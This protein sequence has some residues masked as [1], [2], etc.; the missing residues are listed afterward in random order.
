MENRLLNSKH[1]EDKLN[2][3]EHEKI[4]ADRKVQELE[5]SLERAKRL[6]IEINAEYDYAQKAT[7][8]R[9]EVS[10]RTHTPAAQ[11]VSRGQNGVNQSFEKNNNYQQSSRQTIKQE[12]YVEETYQE[13]AE[14]EEP[15][16]VVPKPKVQQAE[17]PS[18][19]KQPKS[20]KKHDEEE[21]DDIR[22]QIQSFAYSVKVRSKGKFVA[23][24]V[25]KLKK[26]T[27][28]IYIYIV[29]DNAKQ[30]KALQDK[31]KASR[32]YKTTKSF[33]S[34]EKCLK[35]IQSHKYGKN[36]V[37]IVIADYYLESQA[38]KGKMNGLDLLVSL[39]EHDPCLDVIMVSDYDDQELA[40]TAIHYGAAGYVKKGVAASKMIITEI[41]S[42][43][44]KRET[45][46]KKASSK[47]S[48]KAFLI[49]LILAFVALG[50]M[51][52]LDATIMK[53]KFK[54]AFWVKHEAP[55]QIQQTSTTEETIDATDTEKTATPVPDS[56]S[57][58]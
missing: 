33:D 42:I 25:N 14:Y 49:I 16:R 31:F 34:G 3:L 26:S 21:M 57:A 58:Q 30:L 13:E 12:P 22:D 43:T 6:N 37:I 38:K 27:S 47:G 39:K 53:G 5:Q 24:E 19:K 56:H 20:N 48:K 50:T 17:V 28:E 36:S 10:L 55:V 11:T 46:R 54:L 9:D 15:V 40:D 4:I 29:D 51:V 45:I 23:K 7:P 52:G 8:S 41:Q 35:Y 2:S 44:K 32:G 18:S 1:V